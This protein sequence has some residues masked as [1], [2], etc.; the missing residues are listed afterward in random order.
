MQSKLHRIPAAI[1]LLLVAACSTAASSKFTV[2]PRVNCSSTPGGGAVA[3]I[4]DTVNDASRVEQVAVTPLECSVRPSTFVTFYSTSKVDKAAIVFL[5]DEPGNNC[6]KPVPGDSPEKNGTAVFE[7]KVQNGFVQ[8]I[9]IQVGNM[10]KG[11]YRY[12][13]DLGLEPMPN[14]AIII[15][16]D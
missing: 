15:K 10:E 7:A 9:E 4:L 12:C 3:V 1:A 16:P 11:T 2:V 13:A 6:D 8:P 14:P 5:K